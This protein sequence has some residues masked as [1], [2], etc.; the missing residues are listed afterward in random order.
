MKLAKKFI[1]AAKREKANPQF[2]RMV[3]DSLCKYKEEK[4]KEIKWKKRRWWLLWLW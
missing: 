3:F 1:E 2:R 4:E